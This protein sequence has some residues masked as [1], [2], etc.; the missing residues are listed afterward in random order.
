MNRK[1]DFIEGDKEVLYLSYSHWPGKVS[2]SSSPAARLTVLSDLLSSS[3]FLSPQLHS[4]LPSNQKEHFERE[5]TRVP[6]KIQDARVNLQK[7]SRYI[8][9]IFV[10]KYY[11]IKV[12]SLV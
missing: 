4:C 12:F 3:P 7:N 9:S 2:H 5:L 6:R 11:R 10:L 8:F 1:Y